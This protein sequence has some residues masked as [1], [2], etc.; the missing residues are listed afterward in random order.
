MAELKAKMILNLGGNFAR[1]AEKFSRKFSRFSSV[2]QRGLQAMRQQV[3]RTSQQIDGFGN[4]YAAM[5]TGGAVALGARQVAQLEERLA[6]LGVQAQA[7]EAQIDHLKAQIF[8]VSQEREI[9]VNPDQLIG[10]IEQVVEMTGDLDFATSNLRTIGAMISATRAEGAAVGGLMAELQKADIKGPQQV[11]EVLDTL[12]LQGKAGAFTLQHLARLGPRVVAAY[13]AMRPP[14]VEAF[15]ELGAVLQV[16]RQGTGSS[17]QAATSFEALMRVLSDAKKLADLRKGGI[18]VFDEAAL[19]RGKKELRP[20]NQIMTDLI[21]KSRGDKTLLH[22]VLKD[23]EALRAFNAPVAEFNRTGELRSLEKFMQVAGDG[24]QTLADSSRMANTF[25][26]SLRSL[27]STLQEFADL[28]L[29]GPIQSL[30]DAINAIPVARIDAILARLTQAGTVLAGIWAANKTIRLGL[31]A[32]QALSPAL[33]PEQSPPKQAKAAATPAS[34]AP[35]ASAA[36]ARN[37][38]PAVQPV[39][40]TNWPKSLDKRGLANK[41]PLGTATQAAAVGSATGAASLAAKAPLASKPA[42][43]A[44]SPASPASLTKLQALGQKVA[45]KLPLA[46]AAPMAA[47]SLYSTVSSD[48]PLGEKVAEASGTVGG[49]GGALALGGAGAAVGSAVL[50]GPGTLIG[51]G[52][53]SVIGGII[54]QQSAEALVDY[55]LANDVGKSTAQPAQVDGKIEIKIDQQGRAWVGRI[56]EKFGLDLQVDTGDLVAQP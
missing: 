22:Q 44:A 46:V 7:S 25:N 33:K 17:E 27:Y 28:Q 3:A 45:P 40:V 47:V 29:S 32:Q 30:T 23:S 13:L 35:A 51:A 15:K 49:L 31:A 38:S 9:R 16:I 10:A 54:G 55:L 1:Q 56:E 36:S 5:F 20:I 37:K 41:S 24:Q 43:V 18:Q 12:N 52:V 8:A 26:G 14:S 21:Q 50:P 42:P 6:G 19:K 34:A 11:L 2:S 53:G 48:A 4:R 39:R